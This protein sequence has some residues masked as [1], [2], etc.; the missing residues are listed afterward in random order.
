MKI[1]FDREKTI[2]LK[3]KLAK[4]YP[5]RH[6]KEMKKYTIKLII[7]CILLLFGAFL[8]IITAITKSGVDLGIGAVVTAIITVISVCAIAHYHDERVTEIY[9]YEEGIGKY[10]LPPSVTYLNL[11]NEGEILSVEQS[12]DMGEYKIITFYAKDANGKVITKSINIKQTVITVLGDD[13]QEVLD[14]NDGKLLVPKKIK[15]T[16]IEEIDNA[17]VYLKG[18]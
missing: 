9:D 7:S 10:N 3:D 13:V 6:R 18:M 1:A 17:Y 8:C 5:E 4:E 12:E 15:D 16:A 2:E 11:T 14:L